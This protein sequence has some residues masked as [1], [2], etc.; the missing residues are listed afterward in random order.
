VEKHLHDSRAVVDKH[1]FEIVD[2]AVG[3]NPGRTVDQVFDA[4]NQDPSVPRTIEHRDDATFR[5]PPPEPV[6][7]VAPL[8]LGLRDRDRPNLEAT[9]IE[10]DRHATN[11]AALA[12]G[13][14]PLKHDERAPLRSE[15]SQLDLAQSPLGLNQVSL[16]VLRIEAPAEV[17]LGQAWGVG[18][19]GAFSARHG[20]AP[21]KMTTR[22]S[23]PM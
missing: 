6:E 19:I 16:V 18:L 11:N 3:P 21:S 4:L 22:M 12:G 2:L 14:P 15:I 20:A 7:I 8:L 23:N 1:P 17:G 13:V 10:K 5:N 9:R